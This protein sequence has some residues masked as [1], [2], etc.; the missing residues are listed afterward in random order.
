[1][2]GGLLHLEA[3]READCCRN[4]GEDAS[5]IQTAFCP[6]LMAFLKSELPSST[7]FQFQASPVHGKHKNSQPLPIIIVSPMAA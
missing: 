7:R 1:M 2:P 3:I 5:Q 4:V 6:N